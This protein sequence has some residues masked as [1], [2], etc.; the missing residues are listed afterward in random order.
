MAKVAIGSA[1]FPKKFVRR[2]ADGSYSALR[3]DPGMDMD[4]L[5]TALLNEKFGKP[6]GYGRVCRS[7][8]LFLGAAAL[9]FIAV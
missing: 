3:P 7:C 1:Y 2:G 9:L 4:R 8:L 5:Q 6:E